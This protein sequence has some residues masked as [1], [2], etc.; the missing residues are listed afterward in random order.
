MIDLKPIIIKRRNPS[1]NK[2]RLVTSIYNG[3]SGFIGASLVS[4]YD[5]VM[6]PKFKY[7]V[8]IGMTLGSLYI[9]GKA[10]AGIGG[11][12]FYS[13]ISDTYTAHKK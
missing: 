5:F 10:G 8:K 12:L 13:L 11:A 1:Q 2:S 9:P 6:P 4:G 7:P 3:V